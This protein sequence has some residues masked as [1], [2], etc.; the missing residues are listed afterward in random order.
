MKTLLKFLL[1][2][3]LLG[4]AG[5]AQRPVTPGLVKADTS[6]GY[7]L[8][9]RQ[10]PQSSPELFVVVSFSGGGTRAA[11]LGYGVLEALR[12]TPIMVSGHTRRLLDEVDVLSGVSGGSVTAAYYGVHGDAIFSEF[13]PRMLKTNVQLALSAPLVAPA[14]WG[15]LASS[16]F[17][18]TDLA[19]EYFDQ[20]LF[21]GATFGDVLKGGGPLVI[22]NSTDLALGEPFSFTQ[23]SFDW[24][25]A[26]LVTYPVARAVAASSAVPVVF[27]P[28]GLENHAG[29]CGYRLPPWAEAALAERR[30]EN[31]DFRQAERIASY[32]D[33]AQRPAIHLL[34]GAMTDNLGVL[35][36][37]DAVHFAG[38]AEAL[39]Q[40]D[41]GVKEVLFI[42]VDAQNEPYRELL[43]SE[44]APRFHNVMRSMAAMSNHRYSLETV[45]RLRSEMKGWSERL[46]RLRCGGAAACTELRV[47]LA[48]VS[49]DALADPAE[50]N[51]FKGLR[52]AY[53]LPAADVDKLRVVAGRLLRE[54]REFQEFL[55]EVNAP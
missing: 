28:L 54:N 38:G 42:V 52:T 7:R 6:T 46:H 16:D 21:R 44:T 31:R 25:C 19:A 27:S 11:A 33:A 3:I 55:R 24:L 12:D 51:Y 23:D 2:G 43:G 10:R 15:R 53:A 47:H 40:R 37:L 41:G 18:R 29:N 49:F 26:D 22:V 5:C 48:L 30:S 35:G 20:H 45:E 8:G 14:N 9:T 39:L 1:C 4:S 32:L 34:D 13:E 50:R 36:V 17:G